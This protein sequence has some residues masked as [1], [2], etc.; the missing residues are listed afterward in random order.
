M[1]LWQLVVRPYNNTIDNVG[2]SLN[3]LVVFGFLILVFLRNTRMLQSDQSNSDI[4]I[5]GS[6]ISLILC[7]L[8]SVIRLI[9][10][11]TRKLQNT[12]T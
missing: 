1:F 5:Y 12:A 4:I 7:F 6:L 9:V 10:A 2:I 8:I 3:V 11:I